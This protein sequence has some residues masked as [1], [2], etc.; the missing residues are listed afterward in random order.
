MSIKVWTKTIR[1]IIMTIKI[2]I[3]G[4]HMGI[5][6]MHCDTILRLIERNEGSLYENNGSVDIK[7]LKK[8][9]SYAQFFAMFVEL[10]RHK[11]PFKFCLD[12]IDR[13]YTELEKNKEDIAFAA[14]IGDYKKNRDDGKI[15][16]FLTIEEGG[17]IEGKLSNLRNVYRL[18][19]RLMTLTWNYPNEIGYPNARPETM[20]MG[21]TDF[22]KEVVGEMNRLGMIIDVSHLSDG[23]FYDVAKYSAQPFVASHSDARACKNH[24]RNLT[25]DMIRVLSDKGGVTG[26]NFEKSF[27]GDSN[28]SKV[29]DMVRHIEHI[30]NVGGIEV[31]GIGTDFDGISSGLE[32]ENSS[33]LYKLQDA[34]NKHGFSDDDI[35]KI[36]YKNT[37]RV[38]NDVLK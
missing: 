27:L 24:T 23:G 38:I 32:I 35:E 11:E 2:K 37:E 6:D 36:F 30:R 4:I 20:N 14:S 22:G 29:S 21:L 1:S 28:M 5:I 18:G 31:I 19:V 33:E 15:S 34:L 25:D 3:G 26:I 17:V 9:G 16:A 7:K 13:F 8:A 10:K 12:A